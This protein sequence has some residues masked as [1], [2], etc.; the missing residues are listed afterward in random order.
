MDKPLGYAAAGFIGLQDEYVAGLFIRQQFRNNGLGSL[1]LEEALRLHPYLALEVYEKNNGA[2]RFY[3]KHGF[4][5][6][7]EDADLDTGEKEY[8]MDR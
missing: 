7:S 5:I 3:K 1:L 8:W 4:Q 2:V 6:R